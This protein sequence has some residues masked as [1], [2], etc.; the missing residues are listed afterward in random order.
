MEVLDMNKKI[1]VTI[2]SI[3]VVLLVIGFLIFN[4]ENKSYDEYSSN[5]R[6][7][8]ADIMEEYESQF[9]NQVDRQSDI[10]DRIREFLIESGYNIKTLTELRMYDSGYDTEPFDVYLVVIDGN[11]IYVRYTQESVST[12]EWD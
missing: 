9:E 6:D 10:T 12:I 1:V 11:T 7:V 4:R 8:Y 3:L 5:D 2:S